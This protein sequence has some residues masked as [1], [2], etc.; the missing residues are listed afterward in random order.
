MKRPVTV[1]FTFAATMAVLGTVAGCAT[2]KAPARKPS[3]SQTIAQSITTADPPPNDPLWGIAVNVAQGTIFKVGGET[4]VVGRATDADPTTGQET[5]EFAAGLALVA[6][7]VVSTF[8]D[9]GTV[10]KRSS[11]WLHTDN[12]THDTVV[13]VIASKQVALR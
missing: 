13:C 8:D 9:L 11:W 10:P 2:A 12:R 3:A 4:C 5:T 7:S 6:S 1:L